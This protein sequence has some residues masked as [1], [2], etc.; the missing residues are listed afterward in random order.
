MWAIEFDLFGSFTTH[1][2]FGNFYKGGQLKGFYFANA[3]NSLK[4][5]DI[6]PQ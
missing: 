3:L 2:S 6:P 1:H 5:R 4:I